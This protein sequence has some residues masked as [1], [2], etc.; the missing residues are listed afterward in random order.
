MTCEPEETILSS[1]TSPSLGHP[2]FHTPK[3]GGTA[4]LTLHQ[5]LF[6]RPSALNSPWVPFWELTAWEGLD[7]C[8]PDLFVFSW[9]GSGGL[10]AAARGLA[11]WTRGQLQ[12][13]RAVLWGACSGLLSSW[14]R[15]PVPGPQ[16]EVG[17]CELWA[18]RGAQHGTATHLAWNEATTVSTPLLPWPRC[19][20]A[21]LPQGPPPAVAASW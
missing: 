17:A 16:T 5:T 19:P 7:F 2:S 12:G 13:S 20:T 15:P 3:G 18:G 6:L 9:C 21:S 4:P 10:L 14:V 8:F 1:A 11:S